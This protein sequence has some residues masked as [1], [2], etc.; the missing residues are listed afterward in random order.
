[1]SAATLVWRRARAHTCSQAQPMRYTTTHL[2]CCRR[3]DDGVCARIRVPYDMLMVSERNERQALIGGRAFSEPPQSEPHVTCPSLVISTKYHHHHL[4]IVDINLALGPER[5]RPCSTHSHRHH[6]Y[7][8]LHPAQMEYPK[9]S[10]RNYAC[11]DA[12]SSRAPACYYA[13]P[14]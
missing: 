6:S 4:P 7:R 12:S 8:S 2:F 1:M 5:W 3:H 11:M 9:I 10:K 13:C 14:R